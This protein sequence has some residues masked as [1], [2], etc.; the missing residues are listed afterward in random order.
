MRCGYVPMLRACVLLCA[1]CAFAF[2]M[3]ASA[4]TRAW[5]DRDRIALD[6]TVTLN[7]EVDMRSTSAMPDL[8]AVTRDFRIVDQRVEQKMAMV[9]GDISLKIMV[10]MVLSPLHE[11]VIEIPSLWAGNS[12]TAPLRLT[13]LPPLNPVVVDEPPPAAATN[14][15]PVFIE[16]RIDSTTPY[17]Q[18]NVGYTVRLFYET[19]VLIDGRL[20]Q[21]PPAGAS[22][23]KIGDD[24]QRT[25]SLGGRDY[26]VVERHY[27]L[28]PEHSG[29]MTLPP[30]HFIGRGMGLFDVDRQD[31][32][33]FGA[34]NALQVKPIPAI[35]PQPWLPLRALRM[36]YVETPQSLRVG[37]SAA[38]TV[39]VVAEGG[40]TAQMPVLMV[41]ANNGAQ[42]F[43]DPAQM[44]DRFVRDR[45]QATIVRRFS[46]LP[47]REG[48]LRIV[49]PRIEW[50]DA[51]AGVARTASL[52]DLILRV[53]PGAMG[54]TTAPVAADTGTNVNGDAA[55]GWRAWIPDGSWRWAGLAL[56]FL[57]LAALALG[58]RLWS[59]RARVAPIA[60]PPGGQRPA[61]PS[62]GDDGPEAL[63]RA[64]TRGDLGAIVK[65][66]CNAAAPA[67]ADLDAVRARL[68]D[69]AQRAAVDA[70]QRARW[71]DGDNASTLAVLRAAF[72][73]GPRWR[74]SAA[75][76]DA[77]LLP[78]LYPQR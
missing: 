5:L 71:G 57:W 56:A 51:Q 4:Q 45:P 30:P 10:Q 60:T 77:V 40:A 20:D 48:P 2:A 16:A 54:T 52:P 69:P 23:Q 33:I 1:L 24:L 46:I 53:A 12:A 63:M 76:T 21:E 25:A 17:V 26:N 34:P 31:L 11:G 64:L 66:L 8:A 22:L 41:K 50:W 43:P 37:K 49:A 58:W 13:V 29:S 59:L 65:A 67:V 39:E 14:G 9:N 47:T 73:T 6:D 62:P 74:T 27:L 38:V 68:A 55:G 35:A 7:M 32:N 78:P 42:V 36:R 18:Q 3:P 28:I 61:A 70:L 75:R 44:D 72:A 15:R 19:G